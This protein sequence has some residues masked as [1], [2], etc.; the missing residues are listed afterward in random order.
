MCLNIIREIFYS[1]YFSLFRK[2]TLPQLTPA[3]R[4]MIAAGGNLVKLN[5]AP[6]ATLHYGRSRGGMRSMLRQ[7]WGVTDRPSLLNQLQALANEGHRTDFKKIYAYVSN[8]AGVNLQ[9]QPAIVR[10]VYEN[11]QNFKHGDLAAWDFARMINVARQGYTAG[12]INEKEAWE[13]IS[14]AARILQASFSSWHELSD[15]YAL[16]WRFWQNGAP[17]DSHYI[18][19]FNWLK[20]DPASPWMQIAWHTP[21]N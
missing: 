4:W 17:L 8:P 20:T 13:Y 9:G 12:Y 7:W 5:S 15:N 14:F 16:G 10:F 11:R 2:R 6:F 1:L 3:Q 19:T 21:L 18:R